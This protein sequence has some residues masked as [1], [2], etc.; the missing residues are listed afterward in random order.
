MTGTQLKERRTALG[1]TQQ[2]LADLWDTEQATISK[3]E[4]GDHEIKHPRILDDALKHL[5]GRKAN[6]LPI[7]RTRQ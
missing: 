6:G 7:T 4:T 1:L 2:A 3:W 5:E